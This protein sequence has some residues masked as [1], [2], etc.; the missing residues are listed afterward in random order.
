M[1]MQRFEIDAPTAFLL[2]LRLSE[3]YQESLPQI[4]RRL[5]TK[6]IPDTVRVRRRDVVTQSAPEGPNRSQHQ[7]WRFG[8]SVAARS[9]LLR[10]VR[11]HGDPGE[12]GGRVG[13][14]SGISVREFSNHFR[15]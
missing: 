1:L 9:L 6:E 7:L 4:A 14:E 13:R 8:A 10:A 3:N 11:V 15:T 5:L 12:L 2:L